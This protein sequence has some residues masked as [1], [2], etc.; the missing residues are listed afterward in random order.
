MGPNTARL[1]RPSL[2][3]KVTGRSGTISTGRIWVSRVL[4]WLAMNT[5]GPDRGLRRRLSI[6]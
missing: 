6:P 3:T 4:M 1:T 5:K 2:T